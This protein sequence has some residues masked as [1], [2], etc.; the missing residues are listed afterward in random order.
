M[1][2]GAGGEVEVV[3]PAEWRALEDRLRR[4][5]EPDPYW[6]EFLAGFLTRSESALAG[7]AET[8]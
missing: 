5:Q 4:Y 7:Q 2:Y 3:T 6:R 8:F 1:R